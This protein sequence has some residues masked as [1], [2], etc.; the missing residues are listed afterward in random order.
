[1]NTPNLERGLKNSF[2]LLT[3][4]AGIFSIAFSATA[5]PLEKADRNS[6]FSPVVSQQA[7]T[8]YQIGQ[9]YRTPGRSSVIQPPL[10]E[11]RSN[12]VARVIPTQGTVD[13]EVI[14]RTNV[15]VT[16]EAITYTPQRSLRGGTNTTLRNLPAP[17]TITFNRQDEG[18]L[19]VIP[20]TT[21]RN[22]VL[23]V[24]LEEQN[25]L[26]DKLGTIRVQEN[27]QVFLN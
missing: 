27:G 19:N 13:V 26:T 25:R 22:G 20:R 5:M 14:N 21:S 7:E 24:I 18:L 11:W 2:G 4:I 23:Q 15:P 16:Y 9:V 12:A 10:P 17:V 6:Q 3:A 8:G 1:M